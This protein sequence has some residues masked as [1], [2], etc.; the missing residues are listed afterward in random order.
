ML[1]FQNN[2]V[3]LS[4]LSLRLISKPRLFLFLVLE[5]CLRGTILSSTVFTVTAQRQLLQTVVIDLF[6][7]VKMLVY[8]TQ[9]AKVSYHLAI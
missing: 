9:F 4:L 5:L 2:C 6:P 8:A 1:F 7:L 3:T